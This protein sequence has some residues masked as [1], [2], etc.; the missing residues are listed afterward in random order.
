MAALGGYDGESR[1][2]NSQRIM[3]ASWMRDPATKPVYVKWVDRGLPI[4]DDDD[5]PVYAKY[6][7]KSY[8]NITGDEIA[9]LLQF[10][11]EDVKSRPDIKIGSY[12]QIRN[13]MDEPEWWLIWHLDDRLQFRQYSIVKC[14]NIYRWLSLK[15][16]RRVIHEVLGCPRNQSSYNS[17]VNLALPFSNKWVIKRVKT[18]EPKFLDMVIPC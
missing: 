18:V 4:I 14:T 10:R 8:H 2:R 15:D 1:R 11:L 17:G 6:N 9:Y 13:E 12:V 3:D 5:Y 7:V 16:G